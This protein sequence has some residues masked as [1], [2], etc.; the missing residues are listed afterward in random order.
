MCQ[1]DDPRLKDRKS[2]YDKDI[3]NR[4]SLIECR[5]DSFC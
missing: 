3:L 1:A 4:L 5:S 2:Q